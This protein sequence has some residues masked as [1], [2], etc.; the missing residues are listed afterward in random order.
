MG[1]KPPRAGSLNARC[2]LASGTTFSGPEQLVGVGFRCWVAGYKSGD[3][4]C[5]EVVWNAYA[6]ALGPRMAKEALGELAAW[7]RL[8]RETARREIQVSP[9]ECPGFCRDECLAIGMVA[10]S[11][12]GV[13]PAM[14]AC[15]VALLD[16]PHVEDVVE[17]ARGFGIVMRLA[18]QVL[19][20]ATLVTVGRIEGAERP[21]LWH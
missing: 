20:P 7:V 5:W 11:Q 17:Q 3:I 9:Q 19:P 12:H 4:C 8:I 10:A 13:C 14:H 21:A 15:A 1:A 6:R 18:D 16:S 2:R